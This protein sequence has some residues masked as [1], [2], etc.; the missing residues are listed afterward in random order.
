MVHIKKKKKSEKRKN[1]D[2]YHKG[3][4]D[5]STVWPDL[6]VSLASPV[7]SSECHALP[8]ICLCLA[9]GVG[10]RWEKRNSLC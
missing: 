5:K 9:M 6:G 8:F 10:R 2:S 7:A 3:T 1:D 4:R